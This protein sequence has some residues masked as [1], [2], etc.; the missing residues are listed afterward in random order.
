MLAR[1]APVAPMDAVR[2]GHWWKTYT[3]H[4]NGEPHGIASFREMGNLNIHPLFG[5][6]K[7]VASIKIEVFCI[8]SKFWQ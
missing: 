8:F 3:K 7:E 1:I 2:K 5:N 6:V 4:T